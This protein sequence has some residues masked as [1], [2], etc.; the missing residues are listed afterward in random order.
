M[1]NQ[2][3]SYIS[4]SEFCGYCLANLQL[5]CRVRFSLTSPLMRSIKLCKII[6]LMSNLNF[7][8]QNT[9]QFQLQCLGP[10]CKDYLHLMLSNSPFSDRNSPT[11]IFIFKD[12]Y[13]FRIS[14][15]LDDGGCG[16]RPKK[17]LSVLRVFNVR[18]SLVETLLHFETKNGFLMSGHYGSCL[19]PGQ[20]IQ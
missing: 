20:I 4:F 6:F 2:H 19:T 1:P 13:F 15:C 5:T 11:T 12:P 18:D 9:L 8:S 17:I 10:W 16:R 7:I 14:N 3:I